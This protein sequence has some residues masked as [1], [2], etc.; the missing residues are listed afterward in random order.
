[1]VSAEQLSQSA[2]TLF[3]DLGIKYEQAFS[4]VP[5]QIRSLEWALSHLTPHSKVLDVGCGTG[6]PTSAMLAAAG[7][8][9][10]GID[11][12]PKMIGIAK[13]QVPNATFVVADSRTWEPEA[14]CSYDC[15]LVYFSFIAGVLQQDIRDFF[16]RAYS[17]LKPGAILVFATVPIEGEQLHL[18]WMGKEVIGSSLEE[19]GVVDAITAAGFDVEHQEAEMYLPKAKDAGIDEGD[20]HEEPQVFIYARR[21][22]RVVNHTEAMSLPK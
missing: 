3:G 14:P 6:K 12:T 2:I 18:T 20:V 16:P 4:D 17:W 15:V 5:A 21:P 7:H 19:Q 8:D 13:S 1:M 9:V 22:Q 10:L 11:I